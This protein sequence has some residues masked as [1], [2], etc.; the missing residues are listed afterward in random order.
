MPITLRHVEVFHAIMTAGSLT[1][2]AEFMRTSQPTLS[3]E[4]AT[5]ERLL[6]LKLFERRSRRLFATEKALTLHAEVKRSYF[7]LEQLV[8]TAEAIRDNT[9]QSVLIGCLPLFSLTLMPRVCRRILESEPSSRI[10][11]HP[12]EQASLMRDLLALRHEIG[13]VEV[14]VPVDG[15]EIEEVTAGEEVCVLPA[16]H[17]LAARHVISPGDLDDQTLISYSSTDP[18]RARFQRLFTYSGSSRNVRV[19]VPMADAICSLVQQGVG[20][21]LVNPFSAFAYRGRGVVVRRLSIS[22]PF[23]VGICRPRGR[24]ITSLAA[25]AAALIADECRTMA[26]E[27]DT[28]EPPSD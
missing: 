8:H 12:V 13:V 19:E 15:V 2:A 3:R 4:L 11:L 27:F 9:N 6:D 28:P 21:G 14:G 20:V 24:P 26:S 16:G 10:G 5:L 1:K 18:Y 25:S 23:V 17:P 7:G 22:I